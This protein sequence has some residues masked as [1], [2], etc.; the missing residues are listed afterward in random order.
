MS[1]PTS[2]SYILAHWATWL[3]PHCCWTVPEWAR[4]ELLCVA[5]IQQHI[6]EHDAADVPKSRRSL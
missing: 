2:N 6:R 5:L 1:D 3:C 4:E